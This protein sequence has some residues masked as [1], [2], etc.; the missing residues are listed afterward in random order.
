MDISEMEKIDISGKKIPKY[1]ITEYARHIAMRY[2]NSKKKMRPDLGDLYVHERTRE[3][4]HDLIL[5][6][7]GIK[8]VGAGGLFRSPEPEYAE[9][10]KEFHKALNQWVNNYIFDS[11]KNREEYKKEM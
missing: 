11:D 4:L 8:T 6:H 9:E 5:R 10:Y 3:E 1:L 2:I 7:A